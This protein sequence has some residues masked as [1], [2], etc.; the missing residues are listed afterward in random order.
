M[1]GSEST[2]FGPSVQTLSLSLEVLLGECTA[3]LGINVF[4]PVKT[5]SF[6]NCVM[7]IKDWWILVSKMKNSPQNRVPFGIKK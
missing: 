4:R 5:N 1:L 2:F 7:V 6:K 3:G